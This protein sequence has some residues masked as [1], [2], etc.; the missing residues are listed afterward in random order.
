M[1]R[2]KED[3]WEWWMGLKISKWIHAN[4]HSLVKRI[5]TYISTTD[6]RY[7][8]GEKD[9]QRESKRQV[10]RNWLELKGGI[11]GIVCETGNS[12][13]GG[14]D[15]GCETGGGLGKRSSKKSEDK[16]ETGK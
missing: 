14:D 9:D 10:E 8:R 11:E 5:K 1:V 3:R 13:I 2:K 16:S 6:G 7:G 4:Y 15:I 12:W